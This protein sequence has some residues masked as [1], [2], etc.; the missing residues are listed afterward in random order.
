MLSD[1]SQRR[2]QKHSKAG[3]PMVLADTH[4]AIVEGRSLFTKSA[5][6]GRGTGRVLISGHNQRKLGRRVTKGRWAGFEIYTLTLEERKTC[7]RTCLEWASCYGNRMPWSIRHPADD[8]LI[9]KLSVELAELQAKHSGGFV[10]RLH[11]LGD[12]FSVDYVE[13]W[14]AWL[15]QFPA[16]HV[17]GYTARQGDEIATALSVLISVR[18]DRFA[19]RSSGAVLKNIPASV[20]IDT[21]EQVNHEI[22]CP[23]QSDKTACC[24]TC[25]LCWSTPKTIAFLRH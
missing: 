6:A 1:A 24:A 13:K 8:T 25:A 16:L 18:W 22:L 17:F 12:F 21:K 23:V 2:F 4:P 3:K 9:A 10:V 5:N 20:V 19:I 14:G 11:I 7:P 15:D